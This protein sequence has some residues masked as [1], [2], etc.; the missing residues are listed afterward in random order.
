[1]SESHL[2]QPGIADCSLNIVRK[3]INSEKQVIKACFVHDAAY[4]NSK[5]LSKKTALEKTL[6]DI[7]HKNARTPKQDGYHWALA[8]M[9]Y[10][11]FQ[12]KTG[13][14]AKSNANEKLAQ[15]LH[16]PVI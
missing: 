10:K 15:E 16:K 8:S 5:D 3:F 13:S 11:F 1:M 7:A 4:A 12:K 6:K 2:K 9:V 14:G